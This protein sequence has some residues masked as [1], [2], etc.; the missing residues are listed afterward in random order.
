MCQYNIDSARSGP[1]G[2]ASI[3]MMAVSPDYSDERNMGKS[4]PERNWATARIQASR[5]SMDHA[6]WVDLFGQNEDFA[7]LKLK[8]GTLK[9]RHILLVVDG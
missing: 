3:I 8:Y 6:T 1:A 2:N 7:E 9:V 4:M 5:A